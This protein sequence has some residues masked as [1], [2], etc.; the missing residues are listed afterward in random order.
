MDTS[1]KQ[2][3]K[4][5]K[6]DCVLLDRRFF[7]VR[8]VKMLKRH[9]VR[10][11]I[12]VT[13]TSSVQKIIEKA[14]KCFAQKRITL[15]GRE[16]SAKVNLIMDKKGIM[17]RPLILNFRAP[18]GSVKEVYKRYSQRWNIEIA[19]RTISESFMIRTSS[20][21]YKLRYLSYVFS[22]YLYNL[23]L[24]TNIYLSISIYGQTKTKPIISPMM[25][26]AI[27]LSI[28]RGKM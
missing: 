19:L 17:H 3:K 20:K 14:K 16:A 18:K 7:G 4:M 10:F 15:K 8:I 2:L 27:L 9:E 25:F 24:L 21:D 28:D 12:A 6:I 23:W 11:V 22:C 5:Y 13:I 26:M 1:L